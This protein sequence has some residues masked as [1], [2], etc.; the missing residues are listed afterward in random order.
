MRACLGVEE[1]HGADLEIW[2]LALQGDAAAHKIPH[3]ELAISPVA[4]GK[5]T[6][7]RRDRLHRRTPTLLHKLP[8]LHT[9]HGCLRQ[10]MPL[11]R[12]TVERRRGEREQVEALVENL[13]VILQ[14][15]IPKVPPHKAIV[16]LGAVLLELTQRP[17]YLG[18]ECA[19]A[20]RRADGVGSLLHRG[21]GKVQGRALELAVAP[22][23]TVGALR[24]KL[25]GV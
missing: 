25:H 16:G 24:E 12:A 4:V 5:R 6:E 9:C 7:Y 21:K 11:R 8:L 20:R 3:K 14:D 15:L 19:R 2:L 10:R 1:R 17:L 23:E 13:V 18:V 22:H